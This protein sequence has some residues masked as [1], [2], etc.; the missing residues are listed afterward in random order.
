M[1]ECVE[2]GHDF[3]PTESPSDDTCV[4]CVEFLDWYYGRTPDEGAT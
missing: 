3:D 2:C 4:E 1:N